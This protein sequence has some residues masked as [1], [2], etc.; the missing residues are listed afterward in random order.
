MNRRDFIRTSAITGLAA[1]TVGTSFEWAA[2][3]KSKR[4]FTLNFRRWGPG[5]QGRPEALDRI[6]VSKIRF[7]VGG[8]PGRLPGW[9]EH[10]AS[11]N[12]LNG[13]D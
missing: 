2:H 9:N 11:L 13:R 5:Y 4:K 12:D 1:S 3:H 8:S 7:R 6:G 10:K